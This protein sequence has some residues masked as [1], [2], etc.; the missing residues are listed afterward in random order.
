M[1]KSNNKNTKKPN[2]QLEENTKKYQKRKLDTNT[3]I[4]DSTDH[5]YSFARHSK[6]LDLDEYNYS[7]PARIIEYIDTIIFEMNRAK[8][9]LESL[10][11][12]EVKKD[13]KPS[14][15]NLLRI[16]VSII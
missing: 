5:D 11:E 4:Y 13:Y 16:I 9:I 1:L 2:V 3:G 12:I 8:E 10:L 14:F 6:Y 7:L 15:N